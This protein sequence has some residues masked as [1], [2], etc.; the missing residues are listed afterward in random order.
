MLAVPVVIALYFQQQSLEQVIHLSILTGILFVV[1]LSCVFRVT[2]HADKLAHLLGEPYGT[3]ILTVAATIIE[4]TI[5][6]TMQSH[7]N[8]NQTFVRD[9]IAATM[10]ITVGGALGLS[11]LIGG[12]F[13]KAQQVNAEGAMVYLGLLVPLALLILVL[14]NFTTSTSAPTFAASQA[15]FLAL[16]SF[17]LYLIFLFVQTHRNKNLFD[18]SA[19]G[20]SYPANTSIKQVMLLSFLGLGVNLVLVV[21]LAEKMAV[22][23]DIG[24]EERSVP[25][26]LGGVL[27]ALLVLM[28]EVLASI[29]AARKNRLQRSINVALGSGLATLSLSV[30]VMLVW[31]S[32]HQS[33]MVLGLPA[34]DIVMLV[35][36]FWVANIALSTGRPNM[37]QGAVLATLFIGYVFLIIFP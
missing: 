27:V 10:M 15:A 12:S 33:E 3:L 21:L 32:I 23:I 4:V 35:T 6:V 16:T 29:N 7:G 36:T 11:M 24:L 5:M 25:K 30:P 1:A 14:P 13:H 22:W 31:S 17:A 2:H 18:D 20:K 37:M 28:P 19:A 8:V 26:A 9:T 34:R